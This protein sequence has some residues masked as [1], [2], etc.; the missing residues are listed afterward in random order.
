MLK[1]IAK[2]GSNVVLR[3]QGSISHKGSGII[4]KM[5]NSRE[6]LVTKDNPD[7]FDIRGQGT[8]KTL[9]KFDNPD[10]VDI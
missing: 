7:D 10:D 2:G 4:N 6:S 5:S 8:K 3:K 9:I 1:D